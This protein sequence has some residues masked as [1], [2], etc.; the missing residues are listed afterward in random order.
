V[1]TADVGFNLGIADSNENREKLTDTQTYRWGE[2]FEEFCL[3]VCMTYRS[4]NRLEQPELDG[5]VKAGARR[6]G[7]NNK[8]G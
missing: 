5:L 1:K 8:H 7:A 3:S 6:K 4:R 2:F